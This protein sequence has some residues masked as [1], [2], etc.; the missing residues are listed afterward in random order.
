[1]CVYVRVCVTLTKILGHQTM[2]VY[3]ALGHIKLSPVPGHSSVNIIQR[4]IDN[5]KRYIKRSSIKETCP[6]QIVSNCQTPQ[7]K[8]QQVNAQSFNTV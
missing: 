7:G 8:T 6:K 4:I 1:M 5:F 3:V 2:S